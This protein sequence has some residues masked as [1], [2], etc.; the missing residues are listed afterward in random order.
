MIRRPSTG[1]ARQLQRACRSA[2]PQVPTEVE[3][4]LR[5]KLA[6]RRCRD[7]ALV[8]MRQL[9]EI[10]ARKNPSAN[11]LGAFFMGELERSGVT[12]VGPPNLLLSRPVPHRSECEGAANSIGASGPRDPRYWEGPSG[13]EVQKGA[14]RAF[15]TCSVY[16]A[17]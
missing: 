10:G 5:E 1:A 15:L 13:R 17:P 7:G 11:L 14:P 3:G 16:P 4:L 9:L 8:P 6:Y 2:A 12:F